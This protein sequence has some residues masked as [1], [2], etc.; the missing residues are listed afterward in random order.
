M[1]TLLIDTIRGILKMGS[2]GTATP[3]IE[4]VK[5]IIHRRK[6]KK[7]ASK[8]APPPDGKLPHKPA[9]I[10]AQIATAVLVLFYT[11]P[12]KAF[13]REVLSLFGIEF[14]GF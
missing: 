12:G 1:K 14:A 9:S 4:I 13:L 2:F 11:E 3:I 7:A 5:N 10:I 6:Q 8:I